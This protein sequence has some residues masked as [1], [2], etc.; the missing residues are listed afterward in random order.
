MK[1]V[2]VYI[3]TKIL[4][5]IFLIS[6]TFTYSQQYLV[7]SE[8]FATVGNDTSQYFYKRATVKTDASNNVYTLGSAITTTG[9]D[10]LLMKQDSG[11]DTLFIVQFN[12]DGDGE[13]VAMDMWVDSYTEFVYIVGGSVQNTSGE[14]SLDACMV[15]YDN[16]GAELWRTYSSIASSHND[17]Y[18]SITSDGGSYIYCGGTVGTAS[19]EY[20]YLVNTFNFSGTELYINT[21]NYGLND[22]SIKTII[23][24]I[25]GTLLSAGVSESTDTTWDYCIVLWNI[26]FPICLK[27]LIIEV[28]QALDKHIGPQM[29]YFSTITIMLLEVF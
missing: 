17:I 24:P 28:M 7:N 13:D 9:H 27:P 25:N 16:T 23:D 8:W 21:Y 3:K 26:K 4:F 14:D 20:D 6:T 11:G 12:G 15:A 2:Y 18:T 19:N 22:V 5:F 1:P 29:L 10:W